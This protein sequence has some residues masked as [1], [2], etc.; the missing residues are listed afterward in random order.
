MITESMQRLDV[1]SSPPNAESLI[2]LAIRTS[3][4]ATYLPIR[5]WD[6]DG[7]DKEL[8]T[9]LHVAGERDFRSFLLNERDDEQVIR[10]I[11]QV[12]D[13]D[14]DVLE[15]LLKRFN[16]MDLDERKSGAILKRRMKE[17]V[18]QGDWR[19]L[20]EAL[21]HR[22]GG[23]EEDAKLFQ[24]SDVELLEVALGERQWRAA[25]VVVKYGHL[26]P[27]DLESLTMPSREDLKGRAVRN[28]LA[29]LRG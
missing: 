21:K 18:R 11:D 27:G 2:H 23:G 20:R 15:S 22:D 9:R 25:A 8:L 29:G 5:Q 17:A 4:I 12:T 1:N 3:D 10:V 24:E 19:V 7:T 28:K 13:K 6:Q 26:V 16:Q 14:E